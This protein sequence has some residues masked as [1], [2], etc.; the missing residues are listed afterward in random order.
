MTA[1]T[2]A[3]ELRSYNILGEL[4]DE[5]DALQSFFE[6]SG[7]TYVCDAI[8]E[9]GDN[10][11]PIYTSDVWKNA[12][13]I[14]E[15]IEEAIAQGIAHVEGT[16]ID[17]IRIFQAGYYQYYCQ[18]L[19]DNLDT[20][21]FNYIADKINEA[22]NEL[23][24]AT[25]DAIDFEAVE[26]AIEDATNNYDNNNRFYDLEEKAKEIIENIQEGNYAS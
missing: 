13:D 17:L 21:A 12:G 25:L 19:Y 9:I 1:I 15:Y 7:N 16:N 6:Y 4:D 2:Q 24:R 11:I 18:S 23:N 3:V 14:Q 8:T 5:E 26:K 22:V 20:L 10:F